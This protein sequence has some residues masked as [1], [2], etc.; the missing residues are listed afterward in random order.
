MTKSKPIDIIRYPFQFYPT[1]QIF[2]PLFAW[3]FPCVFSTIMM[4]SSFAVRRWH[5]STNGWDVWPARMSSFYYWEFCC[6]ANLLILIVHIVD[7]V[8]LYY[9]SYCKSQDCPWWEDVSGSGWHTYVVLLCISLFPKLYESLTWVNESQ[10]P[11]YFIIV[12]CCYL[13]FCL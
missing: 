7:W 11:Y 9:C 6:F 10:I 8:F 3:F 12:P 4:T 13:F 1:L 5:R 2:N